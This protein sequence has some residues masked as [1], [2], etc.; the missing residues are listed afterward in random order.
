M[1]GGLVG[2]QDPE[3]DVL[4]AAPLDLPRGAHPQAVAR[5]QHAKQGLG[6]V[7]GVAVP[8]RPVR[9]VEGFEVELIDDVLHQPDQ[10][11]LG[12]P[13]AQVGRQ[14]EGLVAV[15]AQEVV[16]HTPTVSK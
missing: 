1:V 3:G 13:V 6:V 15:A 2:G 5:E 12:Q 8:V 14:Q 4:D 10:V 16:G 9:S 11:I 7:G